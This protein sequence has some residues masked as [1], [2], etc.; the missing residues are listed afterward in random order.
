M[1]K[2]VDLVENR[3]S[4]GYQERVGRAYNDGHG[5]IVEADERYRAAVLGDNGVGEG[6]P[7]ALVAEL[8][9][10]FHGDYFFATLPHEDHD[11]PFADG[12][13]LPFKREPVAEPAGSGR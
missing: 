5:V 11:C 9:R 10:R 6:D 4:A 2:H 12:D 1:A 13:L 7:D 8:A 3:W